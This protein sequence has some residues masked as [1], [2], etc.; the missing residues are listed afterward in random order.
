[1]NKNK[2]ILL[3]VMIIGIPTLSVQAWGAAGKEYQVKA[4]F[5]YNFIKFIQWPDEESDQRETIKIAIVGQDPFGNSFDPIL[6][7]TVKNKNIELVH[8]DSYEK[9][10]DKEQLYDCQVVFVSKSEQNHISGMLAGVQGRAILTISEIDGFADKGGM[11]CFKNNDN[12]ISFEINIGTMKTSN[13]KA[14]SQLLKLALRV[15]D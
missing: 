1:M 14:S 11:I 10:H 2:H 15:I 8:F 6:E 9:I 13:I 4:A 3:L 12:K 5:I 7:K